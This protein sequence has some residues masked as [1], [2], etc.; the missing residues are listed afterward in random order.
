MKSHRRLFLVSSP[1]APA[2]VA[3]IKAYDATEAV[4]T[5][6]ERYPQLARLDGVAAQEQ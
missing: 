3:K 2:L 6:R 5:A 4:L 1:A